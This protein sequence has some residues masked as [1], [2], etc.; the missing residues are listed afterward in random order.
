MS[1]GFA[2]P[3]GQAGPL[4]RE[5]VTVAACP[6]GRLPMSAMDERTAHRSRTRAALWRLP[7]PWWM[8]LLTGIAWLI[9]AWAQR[10][11]ARRSWA[12]T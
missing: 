1:P 10:P 4:P 3:I 9:I 2:G 5:V 6:E 8:F 12:P 7:D 11:W